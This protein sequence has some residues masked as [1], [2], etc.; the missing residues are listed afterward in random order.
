MLIWFGFESKQIRNIQSVN[1]NLAA[2]RAEPSAAAEM[3]NY[4]NCTPKKFLP[5]EMDP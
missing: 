2:Q 3:K 4:S 1:S 5:S